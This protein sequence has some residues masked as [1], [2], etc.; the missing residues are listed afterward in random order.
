M[1]KILVLLFPALVWAQG[2]Q[3]NPNV[4]I[5]QVGDNN[6]ISITQ[7]DGNH[8]AHVA[9]GANLPAASWPVGTT[10]T[11][12]ATA[13][14]DSN[15]VHITQQGTGDKTARVEIPNGYNNSV[16]LLQDGT[17]N[18]TANIKNLQGNSNSISIGQDGAGTHVMNIVGQ[19]G[20]T[21]SGNTINATQSGS[22]NKT[23]DLTLAGTSGATVTVTQNN[24]TQSNTGAMGIQC[25]S[26]GS[27][28]YVRN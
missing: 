9:L 22:G 11:T 14:S 15:Y 7:S 25:V 12:G 2:T 19:S 24:P 28:S 26:C 20:T 27:Y 6:I 21:N 13:S 16:I 3:W 17:G 1:K 5:E 8:T 23:F 4:Y 10:A 18:H